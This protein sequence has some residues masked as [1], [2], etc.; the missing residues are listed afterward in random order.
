[1]TSLWHQGNQL[2]KRQLPSGVH[3]TA[4]WGAGASTADRIQL[5]HFYAELDKWSV[6]KGKQ[7]QDLGVVLLRCSVV[8]SFTHTHTQ[9]CTACVHIR[10]HWGRPYHSVD[11]KQFEVIEWFIVSGRIFRCS[12]STMFHLRCLRDVPS[13]F[14]PAWAAEARAFSFHLLLL[15]RRTFQR[16]LQASHRVQIPCHPHQQHPHTHKHTYLLCTPAATFTH[17]P[18]WSAASMCPY[19][20]LN[21]S[22][23]MTTSVSIM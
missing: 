12:C 3:V 10:N 6:F 22:A 13:V 4:D 8:L 15:K 19:C 18:V 9:E 16:K 5:L 11:I 14:F 17:L 20:A 7:Q 2:K 1:M 21:I 23:Q